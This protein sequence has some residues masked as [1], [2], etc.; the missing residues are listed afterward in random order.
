MDK[1]H[2]MSVFVQIAERGSLTAAANAVGKSLPSVVR[3]LACLEDSLQ[4]RLFNRTTRSIALTHE[5]KIYLAQ[6]RKILA[7]IAETERTLTQD[8]SEPNGV[9]TVTAPL[10]FGEMTVTPAVTR[11]L[12][13]YPKTQVNLLLFDR[14]VDLLEEGVDVA[15]RIAHLADSSL[16]AK[17]VGSIR[18]IVCASPDLLAKFGEPR[19]P[20]ELSELPCVNFAGISPGSIWHFQDGGKRLSVNIKA[21]F[22][23]NLAAAAVEACVA[24]NGFGLFLCYQAMPWI[25]KGELKV[26]LAEFEPAPMPLSLV[27]PHARLLSTRVRAMVNC[28]ENYIGKH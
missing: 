16:I 23:C 18:Q 6:C 25:L 5:G 4:V 24:G 15:V 28:L 3:I 10:G 19:H 11:F 26:V 27:Y 21:K 17:S 8:Q 14:V 13:R 1:L 9:I 7:E 2:A 20:E 12:E 22:N